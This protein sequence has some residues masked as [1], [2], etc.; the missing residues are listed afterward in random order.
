MDGSER[1]AEGVVPE[2]R[3]VHLSRRFHVIGDIAILSLH[4]ELEGYRREIATALLEQCGNVHTVFNK[5]SPLQGER[6]TP[7]GAFGGQRQLDYRS[8]RVWLPLSSGCARGLFQQ[9]SGLRE[10][11]GG[12]RGEGGGGGAGP[13]RR[14]GALC[15]PPAA[16]GARVVALEK[17]PTACYWL[18]RNARE[19]GVDER[20]AVINAD[21]FGA[22]ILLKRS[23]DRAVVPTPMEWT[24]L[25]TLCR[26]C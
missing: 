26:G 3:L 15:H 18:A 12:W 25:L 5:A 4:P 16:R 6:R 14:G 24:E 10:D 11:E 22:A 23:F 1:E 9:P 20:V 8:Q 13:I 19:N 7:P 21:A 2:E 17:S